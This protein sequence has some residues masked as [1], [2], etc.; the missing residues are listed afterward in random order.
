MTLDKI[1]HWLQS[2]DVEGLREF[3]NDGYGQYLVG[4][5]SW[6][7]EVRQFLK[8][9]P[10]HLVSRCLIYWENSIV[11]INLSSQLR[12]DRF[13]KEIISNNCGKKL[14]K[15]VLQACGFVMSGI[16]LIRSIALV[17]KDTDSCS[18]MK[19]A[20][21]IFKEKTFYWN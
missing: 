20:E 14:L 12:N 11:D 19:Y 8:T 21:N 13:M 6:N 2:G 1:T 10:T 4:K 5:T 15:L 16:F 9:V 3:V 7:E 18:S 17:L